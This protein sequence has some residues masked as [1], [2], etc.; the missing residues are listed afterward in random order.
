LGWAFTTTEVFALGADHPQGPVTG[1]ELW[2]EGLKGLANRPDRVHGFWVNETDV[3]FYDGDG[4][5]FNQFMDAYAK[6]KDTALRVVI[7]PGRKKARSPWDKAERDIPVA[8][9]LHGSSDPLDNNAVQQAGRRYYSRVDVWLGSQLKLEELRIP[10]NVEVVSGGEIEKF[11]A[12]RQGKK[13][14][15]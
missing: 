15:E 6:L 2:P 8:W 14:K 5:A 3:F 1:N 7:H 10:D 13:A 9:S 11:I 4:K 12:D